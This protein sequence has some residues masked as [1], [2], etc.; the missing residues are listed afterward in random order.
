VRVLPA[1]RRFGELKL[2]FHPVQ[3]ASKPSVQTFRARIEIGQQ[4]P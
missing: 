3:P 4:S 2:S 1:F